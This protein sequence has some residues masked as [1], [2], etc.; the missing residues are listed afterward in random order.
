MG[1]EELGFQGDA[2]IMT[3]EKIRLIPKDHGEAVK[4]TTSDPIYKLPLENMAN[5]LTRLREQN[6]SVAVRKVEEL[7]D[8]SYCPVTGGK[9]AWD[10]KAKE[11]RPGDEIKCS[12]LVPVT[13]T[14]CNF[15][16][17]I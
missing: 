14:E 12:E 10:Y 5:V 7:I 17:E 11:L 6:N 4:K 13:C 16:Y 3:G 8:N 1:F 9:H 15:S 2:R